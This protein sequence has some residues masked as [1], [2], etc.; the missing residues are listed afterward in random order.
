MFEEKKTKLFQGDIINHLNSTQKQL[1]II[2][3]N[4]ILSNDLSFLIH[5]ESIYF[6]ITSLIFSGSTS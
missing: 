1:K 4:K 5:K 2:N 6:S 3:L